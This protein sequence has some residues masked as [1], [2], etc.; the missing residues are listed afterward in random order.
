M[1]ERDHSEGTVGGLYVELRRM[2]AA[3][4]FKPGE[5]LNET[6][7]SR[8][9]GASR[10]PLRE[11][12]NR[13]VA[14]GFFEFR[15]GQGFFCRELSPERVVNLYQ[16][17]M[18]IECEAARQAASTAKGTAIDD[19]ESFLEDTAS[20]YAAT[21]DASRLLELDET[22]H[23]L[24]C[25]LAENPEFTR[26]LEN[27]YDRIRFVRLADLRH[28][29]RTRGLSPDGHRGILAAIRLG[30]ADEAAAN[31]RRHIEGRYPFVTDAVRQAYADL[32]APAEV[33]G[34]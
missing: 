10:T 12:L 20:E 1:M 28:L 21:D 31:M 18:A 13:L 5:R 16:A 30:D 19:V 27:I 6:V 33:A 15:S 26:L 8:Q 25:G 7:L 22:F 32:Y 23:L 9:L 14:E 34:E 3:F 2:A 11:A 4:A 17:R 29:Q 24:V